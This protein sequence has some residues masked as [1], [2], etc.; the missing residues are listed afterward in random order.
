MRWRVHRH[1]PGNVTEAK[2]Y[3]MRE[4][5]GADGVRKMRGFRVTGP[6]VGWLDFKKEIAEMRAKRDGEDKEV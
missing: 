1:L 2:L 4:Y 3:I 6:A 5:E